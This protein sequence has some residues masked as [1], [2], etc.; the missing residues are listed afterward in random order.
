[1]EGQDSA[2]DLYNLNRLNMKALQHTYQPV[3]E[4]SRENIFQKFFDWCAG[5][6]ENRYAW[7]AIALFGHG[8][9]LAPVTLLVSFMAGVH[10]VLFAVVIASMTASVVVNLA[11]MP[12]RVT[13]PVFFGS[14]LLNIGVI[15]TSLVM[16]AR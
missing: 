13:I 16:M 5:Q 2:F 10:I 12:T 3:L 6:D 1:M 9:I 7:L 8:C 4:G 15:I 11:A 14:A